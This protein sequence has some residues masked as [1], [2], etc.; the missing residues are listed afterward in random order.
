M[1]DVIV[2][3]RVC[4]E[5]VSLLAPLPV[6]RVNFLWWWNFWEGIFNNSVPSG[7]SVFRQIREVQ[8]KPFHKFAVSQVLIWK[9]QNSQYI[10][11][12]YFGVASCELVQSY[13]GVIYSA[14]L[15][16]SQAFWLFSHAF[17]HSIISLC[18]PYS[19][20]SIGWETH[21]FIHMFIGSFMKVKWINW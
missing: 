7:G 1:G 5:L 3:V 6:I 11:V 9:T 18:H 15:R 13:L 19:S 10:K 4:L 2:C 12:V 20:C 17:E 8:R 16:Q 14:T 21:S